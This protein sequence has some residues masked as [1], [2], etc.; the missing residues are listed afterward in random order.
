[1][2]SIPEKYLNTN[3][4]AMLSGR[5]ETFQEKPNFH[6][7]KVVSFFKKIYQVEVTIFIKKVNN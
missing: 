3:V 7:S 1:M 5:K 2:S 6:F 4:R